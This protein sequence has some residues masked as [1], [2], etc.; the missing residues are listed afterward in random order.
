MNKALIAHWT[1][2]RTNKQGETTEIEVQR[3]IGIYETVEEA[4]FIERKAKK[5]F[6]V[7][8]NFKIENTKNKVTSKASVSRHL[9]HLRGR[10]GK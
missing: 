2:D 10:N 5:N 7:N 9:E 6:E 8:C 1:Y 3:L 4:S